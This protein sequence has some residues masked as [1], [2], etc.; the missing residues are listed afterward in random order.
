MGGTGKEKKVYKDRC[1]YENTQQ[2]ETY[3][4]QL[5]KEKKI[6]APKTK[7]DIEK[8][9]PFFQ[10][11]NNYLAILK[12]D[13][14]S[15]NTTSVNFTVRKERKILKEWAETVDG[16]VVCSIRQ[17]SLDQ[18]TMITARNARKTLDSVLTRTLMMISN[19]HRRH[20]KYLSSSKIF[21][22]CI[23]LWCLTD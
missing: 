19:W 3:R 17:T 22:D 18:L 12:K 21:Q 11:N 5:T 14:E 6:L 7:Q 10:T 2:T 4:Q 1:K 9:D 23:L 15:G 20:S 16:L 13:S 8:L